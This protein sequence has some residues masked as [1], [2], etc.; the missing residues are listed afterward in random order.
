MP[1]TINA[2]GLSIVHKGSGGEAN[3]TSPDVCLT[4][5]GPA[6]VPI[7]YGNNAKSADLVEGTATVSADGGNSIAIKGSKFAVSTGDA[8]GDQKGISSGTIEDEAEFISASAN[9]FI[10]GKG[11]ARLSDQMTMNKGNTTCMGGVQN[12]CVTVSPELDIPSTCEI[13][14]RYPNGKRLT[15]APYALTDEGITPLGA[16]ALDGSGK[17]FVSSLMPGKVKLVMQ[18]SQDDFCLSP[19][20]RTNPHCIEE[21][22]D[23]DF[24]DKARKRNQGFWQPTRVETGLAPW[25]AIGHEL[26]TDRYFQDIVGLETRLHFT[27][28]HPATEFSLEKSC[29]TLVGN[30]N[31]PLPHTTEALLAYTMPM[32]LEEGEILSAILR[33]APYETT[34]RLLAFIRARGE[35]N[36]QSYLNDYDWAAAKKAVNESFDSLLKKLQSRLEFLRDQASKLKYA[37][38]SDELFKK[39]INTIK[40]YGKGLTELIA[41][42]FAKMQLRVSTLMSNTANVKVIKAADNVYS[43]EAGVIETVVNTTQTID[44][45]EPFMNEVPGRIADVLPI[46][47]VR[48]GYANFFDTIMPAQAPPTLPEMA[49]ASGLNETGGYILRLLREGWIYIK[50]EEG[51]ADNQQIHIFRYAQTETATGVIEKFEKYYFTNEENAQD[52]LTLDISSGA[53]FYPFAFVTNGTQKISIAYSEHEWAADIIDKM[54]SDQEWRTKAMQQVDMAASDDFSDTATQDTLSR[55][56]EDYRSHDVKWL[57]DQN[58]DKPSKYGLDVFTT[59]KNYYLAADELVETMQKSHSEQKDGTLVAL[60]DPV[61]RQAEM[62]FVLSLLVTTEKAADN[63]DTYPRVIGDIIRELMK[64]DKDPEIRQAVQENINVEAMTSFYDER[65]ALF[66]DFMTRRVEILKLFST[67]A[68]EDLADG[69]LGALDAYFDMYFSE[70]SIEPFKEVQKLNHIMSSVMDGLE[71]TQEGHDTAINMM[72]LAYEQGANNIYLTYEE[73]LKLILLQC[74]STVD[75]AELAATLADT[76]PNLLKF[77]WSWVSALATYGSDTVAKTALNLKPAAYSGLLNFIPDF[78]EKGFG[79]V[80][81][82]GN[83]RITLEELGK[84]LAEHIDSVGKSHFKMTRTQSVMPAATKLIKWASV[85][86]TTTL[87]RLETEAD[88]KAVSYLKLPKYGH[89][90]ANFDADTTANLLGKTADGAISMLS[91]RANIDMLVQLTQSNQFEQ[92]DPTKS[93]DWLSAS[94]DYALAV[95]ALSAA[96][97]DH[98][99][100][101]RAQLLLAKKALNSEKFYQAVYAGLPGLLGAITKGG[102]HAATRVIDRRLEQLSL[103]VQSKIMSGLIGASN[104][105]L[106]ASSAVDAVDAYET[107]NTGLMYANINSMIAYSM[108]ATGPLLALR[109]ISSATISSGYFALIGFSLLIVAESMKL[110]YGKTDLENLLFRC[111]WGNSD[112]YAFWYFESGGKFDISKRLEY[113]SNIYDDPK[114]MLAMEIEQQEFK[115]LLLRPELKV[116]VEEDL[117]RTKKVYGYRIALP[118][119]I[120]GQSNLIGMVC[121]KKIVD[122]IQ[123]VNRKWVEDEAATKAFKQ[124]LSAAA[125]SE[126]FFQSEMINGTLYLNFSVEMENKPDEELHLHWYYQQSPDIIVPKRMLTSDGVLEKTYYGMIDDKPSNI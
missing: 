99:A 95:A 70:E 23:D 3:A 123:P 12:P 125:N 71:G 112:K 36:P 98:S 19:V 81:Q 117:S 69:S 5:V 47:P 9:V 37:Y 42:V 89:R 31:M 8:D 120:K 124:A 80:E 41:G 90:F 21:I 87:P 20:R 56:V 91:L 65:E 6:V 16:G 101:Q 7:P 92:A 28:V 55:L 63:T 32:I 25:G 14:V 77:F 49:S 96:I 64:P 60:F 79:I 26:T 121:S 61:G 76:T 104:L 97:V 119:Y 84:I 100:A 62:S 50:E 110:K 29:E 122:Y 43:A 68:F 83:V 13:C 10:E 38:L 93:H 35:G 72:N 24:F 46:Y 34:D 118:S 58:K 11:V 113:S 115:N 57:A 66:S 114:F 54:N 2:N 126:D 53:T 59:A 17:S 109:N 22:S 78:F 51:K 4:T 27:H 33:L 67:F 1:V 44:L 102:A 88:N 108:F 18:E 111:F 94:Q 52:G 75:W 15:N 85:E 106:V 39:H 86:K 74:Q 73:K 116:W 107:G 45:V 30:L 105:A 103:L 40:T 82:G 48:Y